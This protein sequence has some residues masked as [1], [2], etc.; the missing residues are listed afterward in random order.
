VLSETCITCSGT[1]CVAPNG[2]KNCCAAPL[3]C[4]NS[5]GDCI[6]SNPCP[7]GQNY[8]TSTQIGNACVD[9]QSNTYHCGACRRTCVGGSTAADVNPPVAYCCA[10]QCCPGDAACIGGVCKCPPGRTL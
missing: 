8:C 9:L 5:T 10:G 6:S 2:A 1:L 7:S 3:T 4:D